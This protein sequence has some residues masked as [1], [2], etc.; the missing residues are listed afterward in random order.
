MAQIIWE[1]AR[2]Q[3]RNSTFGAR[4]RDMLSKY[5]SP[6]V[7]LVK[8]RVPRSP[9]ISIVASLRLVLNEF[10][11][12]TKCPNLLR[13]KSRIFLITD[14]LLLRTHVAKERTSF[15]SKSS[16]SSS[17]SHAFAAACPSEISLPKLW[18]LPKLWH[19]IPHHSPSLRSALRS[20]LTHPSSYG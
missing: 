11:S 19:V 15:Y 6:D 10:T 16:S 18:C 1:H 9:L 17:N 8:A 13:K 20:W 4:L 3:R 2:T 7:F 12:A 5:H 14:S